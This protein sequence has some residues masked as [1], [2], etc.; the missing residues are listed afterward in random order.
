MT[1]RW[2]GSQ[3]AGAGPRGGALRELPQRA[4]RVRDAIAPQWLIDIVR[5][6][7]AE[8]PWPL[9]VRAALAI[10]VP[11]AAGMAA[12]RIAFGLLPAIG[13][14]IA[15]VVDV[16]GPYRARAR[17][18]GSA[19]V[20]GGAVG[21]T[22]GTVIHGRGWVAVVVL[23]GVAGLS[24]LI[25]ELG[26]TGSVTGLQLLVYAAFGFGPLGGLRPWWSGPVEF[27]I[28]VAW[29]MILIIPGWILYPRAAEQ[30][31]VAAVYRSLADGLRAAGTVPAGT[32]AAGAG[33]YAASR[34]AVTA[35]LNVAYDQ[36]L[37]TR[38]GLGGANPRLMR[39]VALLNH[40]HLVTEAITTLALEGAAPPARV[41]DALGALADS[42]EYGTPPPSIPPLWSDTPGA[43][44]LYDAL[45]GAAR[46]LAG[47]RIQAGQQPPARNRRE[48]LGAMLEKIRG[49]RLIRMF[50]VRLMASI[51]VA[52]VLS[53]ILPLQRSYWVVLTVAIVL[54]PDFGSVFAR[55]LQRGIG[56]IVG[57]V[58]G[59][60]ILAVVPYGPWLLIPLAV[61]AA[62]LPYGRSVNYGLLSTFL[63][64]L[65]VVLIDLLDRGGWRL[66]EARLIDTLLGCAVALGVG[67]APWPASWQA[68]LPGQ[69]A[70]AVRRVSY[71]SERGLASPS[72]DRS[73]LRRQTYRCLSDLLAEFQRSMSQP[74]AISRQ[75]TAW[76]PA[77]VGLEQVVDAVTATAVAVDHGAPAPTAA[78]VRQLT[79]ALDRIAGAVQAGP[80]PPAGGTP[81]AAPASLADGAPQEGGTPAAEGASPG[82]PAP[83]ADGS[84]QA[85]QPAAEG[86]PTEAALAPVA[87]AIRSVQAV[88]A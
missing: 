23:I 75:A 51:G 48:R 54:K 24:V 20:F 73:R 35:A 39:L 25:S 36:L 72:P 3:A 14:L 10:C 86:L 85:A 41:V 65:V 81:P 84:P 77:L 58:A 49:G 5:P 76:W 16:G 47:R 79:D 15:V 31:S 12:H 6:R 32:E 53:D 1:A 27:L 26:S 56:T 34:R 33:G 87:D 55:A 28:G 2:R 19:T 69:F 18:V 64:P 59:A 9:M 45:T 62:L 60:I 4:A 22:I 88:V 42:I 43:R 61:L 68:H 82:A 21:L 13:G 78:G 52:A 71:Y 83:P 57:A 70:D 8:L 11:L 38:S 29:A 7:P 63:T 50:A 40:S 46:L 44:A 67:Y 30:H 66:A 17:R 80:A 37:T 74:C